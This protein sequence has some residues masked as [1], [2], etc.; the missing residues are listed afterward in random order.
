[1][2]VHPLSNPTLGAAAAAPSAMPSTRSST[3]DAAPAV[4]QEFPAAYFKAP[5]SV[6]KAVEQLRTDYTPP[7]TPDQVTSLEVRRQLKERFGKDI[8]PDKTYLVSI[9]YDHRTNTPPYSGVIVQ[10]ISLTQAARLN[11]QD[12]PSY[13]GAIRS[14]EDG[15]FEIRESSRHTEEPD[16]LGM[17]PRPN[18]SGFTSHFQGIYTEPQ[19]GSKNIY[20][21]SNRVDISAADFKQMVWDNSYKT[22]YDQ[23]LENYWNNNTRH[24][25][26]QASRGA[27]LKASHTQHHDQSLTENDR[28]IAM[29][30]AGLP[31][32]KSYSSLTSNDLEQPYKAD[33]NLET[34]FLTFKGYKMRAF[35]TQDKSTGRV[36]LYLPDQASM[37]KGFDSK[38]EMNKWLA[39]QLK[40]PEKFENFK[41]YFRPQDLP[42]EFISKGVDAHIEQ[43]REWLKQDGLPVSKQEKLGYFN[44]G[45]LF[46]GE[47]VQGNPFE[48]LQQRTEQDLKSATDFQFV[49]NR[50]YKANTAIKYLS[51]AKYGLL[52]LAPLGLA[53][54]PLGIALTAASVGLG[55]A[56]LGFGI[57]SHVNKRP[58]ADKRIIKG[59]LNTIS[60]IASSG[61]GNAFKP[62]SSALKL[63][64][65]KPG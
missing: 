16:A 31:A 22:P 29:G 50:D 7:K 49:L 53:Y 19:P 52:L 56:E 42:N 33:P 35:Y 47:T 9:H 8:D 62:I 40:D 4:R 39:E 21:A 2:N 51:W 38:T 48:E 41:L 15:P 1:M 54:P 27:F 6:N 32:D 30:V 63:L 34:K 65:M 13:N 25:Y 3:N 18:E 55:G 37:L 24:T 43:T 36:L 45:G 44:E 57:D 60:P 26:S 59:A 61:M 64:A 23:Y 10:K 5:V 14:K 46:D 28:K 58:N 12:E 11:Q 20:D 17:F